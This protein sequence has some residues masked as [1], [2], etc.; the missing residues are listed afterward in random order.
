MT[1]STIAAAIACAVAITIIIGVGSARARWLILN[2]VV[3]RSWFDDVA[4][5]TVFLVA[6]ASF[7]VNMLAVVIYLSTRDVNMSNPGDRVEVAI[8]SF[9]TIAITLPYASYAWNMGNSI[10]LLV[11]PHRATDPRVCG[12]RIPAA[13]RRAADLCWITIQAVYIASFSLILVVATRYLLS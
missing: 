4:R 10:A 11:M 6:V 13:L 1:H 7:T 3:N 12:V 8:Y 9:A 5:Y 2:K